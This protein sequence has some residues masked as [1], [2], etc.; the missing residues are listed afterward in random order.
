M[1]SLSVNFHFEFVVFA[2]LIALGRPVTSSR[3]MRPMPFWLSPTVIRLFL[4]VRGLVQQENCC[5]AL[6][7]AGPMNPW[8]LGA[9]QGARR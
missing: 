3:S 8:V 1:G 7:A 6:N 2:G 9:N 5:T 4:L